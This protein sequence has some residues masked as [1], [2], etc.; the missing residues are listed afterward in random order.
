MD[1]DRGE[2]LERLVVLAVTGG[3]AAYKAC[4]VVRRLRDHGLHVNVAM[5]RNATEFV[6]PLT[7]AALSGREVIVDMFRHPEPQEMPHISWAEACDAL[8][9]VPAS[10]DFIAK[11]A[12]GIADDFASTLHLAVSS[13]ILVAPA[14]EDDMVRH[15][16]VQA[17]LTT[18]RARGVTVV[19]PAVGE[20]ASGRHG[21][22]R[23]VEPTAIV[24]TILQILEG[25]GGAM[26]LADRRVLVSAGPTREALD[27]IRFLTNRS[28]GRMGF[29]IAIAARDRGAE[30][31]LV[32][33][34]TAL[35]TPPGVRPIEVES[36]VEMRQAMLE[37]ARGADIVVMAAAVAD[38]RPR[39]LSDSKMKKGDAEEL[40]LELV[41]NPDILAEIGALPGECTVVGFA[42]E[43]ADLEASAIGKMQVK[44]CDLI[45]ANNLGVPGIGPDAED[46]EVVVLDRLGGRLEIPKAPKSVVADR[47]IDA[48]LAFRA[49]LVENAE[50]KHSE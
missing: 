13:P 16:A 49:R 50:S 41:R 35:R 47:L 17:N 31:V 37:E 7:F 43:S 25:R 12:L 46:N 23:M 27:P 4:E 14:M 38:W 48:I 5:T 33:G 1:G 29:A 45:V 21:A 34:P 40:E 10:A 19:G 6:T 30:V 28:S 15:P 9:V 32:S 2:P 39:Q 36:A 3:I 26:P 20:L 24:A 18:L 44:V 11:M 42:A 22:G 8:C